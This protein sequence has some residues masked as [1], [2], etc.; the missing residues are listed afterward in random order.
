[1]TGIAACANH[2]TTCT[3]NSATATTTC[4]TCENGWYVAADGTCRRK[5]H[6]R[7]ALK[8]YPLIHAVNSICKEYSDFF[9]LGLRSSESQRRQSSPKGT[10]L[11]F[12]WNRGGVPLLRKPA[13]SLKRGKIG[14]RLL[15]M[16]NRKLHTRFR[17]VSKSANTCVF[18]SPPQKFEW[19]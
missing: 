6:L 2:C 8:A 18:R 19:R 16:T 12:A 10:P 3:W 5:C 13:L 9:S 4:A 14:P 1:M 7:T 15:L 17:L 11:K